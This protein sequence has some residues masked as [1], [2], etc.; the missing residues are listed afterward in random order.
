MLGT[1]GGKSEGG[2]EPA[3]GAQIRIDLGAFQF[4]PTIR[5]WGFNAEWNEE[6]PEDQAA[7]VVAEGALSP[8]V[9]GLVETKWGTNKFGA[10]STHG[11][12][13][14]FFRV[15]GKVRTRTDENLTNLRAP[16]GSAGMLNFL[17]L[18]GTPTEGNV[19]SVDGSLKKPDNGNFYP[20][21]LAADVPELAA[22]FADFGDTV[23]RSDGVPTVLALWQ[24]PDH[25]IGDNLTRQQSLDR[26]VTF[27]TKAGTALRARNADAMI[28]GAQQNA[29][30][31]RSNGGAIDGADYATWTATLLAQEA[32]DGRPTPLDFITIQNYQG[33]ASGEQIQNARVAYADPRFDTAT[34]MMNE[35][36]FDKTVPFETSYGT[37]EGLLR[38]LGHLKALSD[39]PDLGYVLV[40]R[41]LFWRADI[42]GQQV[43]VALSRMPEVRRPIAFSGAGS[44]GLN[45]IAA[46]DEAQLGAL[47]WNESAEARVVDLSLPGGALAGPVV[48]KNLAVSPAVVLQQGASGVREIRGLTIPAHAVV[49][50]EAGAPKKAPP[51]VHAR[52]SRHLAYTER[53]AKGAAPNAM[54]HYD[55]RGQALIAAVNDATSVGLSGVVLRG[56]PD[57]GAGGAPYALTARLTRTDAA[58]GPSRVL[59]LRVDY[60]DRDRSLG[61]VFYRDSASA[62]PAPWARLHGWLSPVA[63]VDVPISF[64][65]N[66][67]LALPIAA[68]APAAWAT[69]DAGA[70]RIQVSLVLI[71]GAS[72]PMM[73]KAELGE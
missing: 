38:T 17:Q 12:D 66:A 41:N 70:R 27:F 65:A 15:N 49:S 24:E 46:A 10:T 21:P 28:A 53:D 6:D 61:T 55:V 8:M 69:A 37:P 34:L 60:L 54:G 42:L 7:T 30:S 73:V 2:G 26:Y 1:D 23:M 43:I 45:G 18:A 39:Q 13:P 36:D 44:E 52:Y 14:L 47:L 16:V 56:V 35:W 5:R 48:V 72:G 67:S 32:S 20:L 62:G 9:G 57:Q 29:A 19:F 63:P 4:P 68:R 50:V 25:T 3:S 11:P 64:A 40:T 58:G 71:G 51:M 22:A 59:G 33:E 31:G